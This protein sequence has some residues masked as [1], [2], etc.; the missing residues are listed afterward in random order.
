MKDSLDYFERLASR[1]QLEEV[2]Q[3]DVSQQVVLRLAE[4]G[5]TFAASMGVFA[6]G[7]AA[8]AAVAL[9]YGLGLLQTFSDPLA[10][11]FQMASVITP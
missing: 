7:Y 5:P 1:A 2:P 8:A 3:R 9:V 4:R 6:V 11:V 10:S